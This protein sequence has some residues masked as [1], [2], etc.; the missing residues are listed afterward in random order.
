LIVIPDDFGLRFTGTDNSAS[1]ETGGKTASPGFPCA[2]AGRPMRSA[3]GVQLADC[4]KSR[5]VAILAG[6][7]TFSELV[8]M[9]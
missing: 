7:M 9:N 3:S 4:L 2:L 5:A 1:A 8:R 6:N